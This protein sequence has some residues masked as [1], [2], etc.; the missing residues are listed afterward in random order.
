MPTKITTDEKFLLQKKFTISKTFLNLFRV[1]IL[2][3]LA[4]KYRPS[5]AQ[6][7]I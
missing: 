6:L 1:F 2:I 4:Q 5:T 3:Q 7:N